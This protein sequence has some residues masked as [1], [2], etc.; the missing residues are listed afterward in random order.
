M[1]QP[2]KCLPLKY[3]DLSSNPSA[4]EKKLGTGAYA[5]DLRAREVETDRPLGSLDSQLSPLNTIQDSE[6]PCLKNHDG[7]H[8]YTHMH[9]DIHTHIY[10]YAL[11]YVYTH[12]HM[13][14]CTHT[15]IHTFTYVLPHT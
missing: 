9:A 10:T 5:C 4:T 13:N 2:V 1:T 15:Y 12:T 11:T 8:T 14:T 7:Q 3:E 6:N